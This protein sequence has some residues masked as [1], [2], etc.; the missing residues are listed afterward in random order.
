M[1]ER[2]EPTLSHAQVQHV[3]KL[4]RLKLSDD[5]IRR[6]RSELA[7][8]LEHIATLNELDLEG[9]EPLAH[10]TELSNRLDD[11][12]ISSTMPIE[13]LHRTAPAIEGRFLAVPKVLDDHS[14]A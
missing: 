10:P 4:C 14:S 13:D 2:A 7:T 3:A 11:D 8:V 6:Y 1:S 12:Q 5:Q 9:V